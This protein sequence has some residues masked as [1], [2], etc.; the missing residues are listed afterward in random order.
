MRKFSQETNGPPSNFWGKYEPQTSF[1]HNSQFPYSNFTPASLRESITALTLPWYFWSLDMETDTA[2]IPLNSKRSPSNFPIFAAAA[3][4]RV[5]SMLGRRSFS[6]ELA[7]HVT[8]AVGVWITWALT[9]LFVKC[10]FKIYGLR[11]LVIAGAL[12]GGGITILPNQADLN[13]PRNKTK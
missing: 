9:K 1:C 13:K 8:V 7:E 4:S 5:D 2:G 11:N 12:A 6:W 3:T 10:I